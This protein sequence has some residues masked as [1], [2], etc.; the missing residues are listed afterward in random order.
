MDFVTTLAPLVG[1]IAT[2]GTVS[3]G[4]PQA[5][6][7]TR[8]RS[9]E[10]VSQATWWLALAICWPWGAYGFSAGDPFLLITNILAAA[11][12][13]WVLAAC[14]RERIWSVLAATLSA[15]LAGVGILIASPMPVLVVVATAILVASRIPQLVLLFRTKSAKDVSMATWYL[16]LLTGGSWTVYGL[17]QGDAVIYVANGLATALTIVIIVRLYVIQKSKGSISSDSTESPSL[18]VDGS[19][20]ENPNAENI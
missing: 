5:I 8:D 19:G 17:L 16:S 2:V 18:T 15:T 13:I 9:S 7:V 3:F 11:V 10:G 12:A 4:I 14:R 20:Q 6:K 1:I